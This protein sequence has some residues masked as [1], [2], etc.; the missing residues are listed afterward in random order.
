M[1]ELVCM[2][3]D[4]SLEVWDLDRSRG[5]YFIGNW[6][7]QWRLETREAMETPVDF[8]GP[9]FWGREVLGPL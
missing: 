7:R 8:V 4:G 3:S 6:Y 2:A 1:K 9:E 5:N